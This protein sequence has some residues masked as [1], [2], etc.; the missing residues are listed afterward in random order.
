MHDLP[1]GSLQPDCLANID[2]IVQGDVAAKLVRV[3]KVNNGARDVVDAVLEVA[4]LPRPPCAVDVA[5]VK[6]EDG[7]GSCGSVSIA[8]PFVGG[9]GHSRLAHLS[10]MCP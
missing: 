2:S 8:I 3:V 6:P 10:A 5:V 9:K 7:V 1:N 4:L